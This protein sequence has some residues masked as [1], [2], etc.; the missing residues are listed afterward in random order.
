VAEASLV[1]G[2]DNIYAQL[3]RAKPADGTTVA[4]W[5]VVNP[6]PQ[7]CGAIKTESSMLDPS[8]VIM[9]SDHGIPELDLFLSGSRGRGILF[10]TKDSKAA[11]KV[12]IPDRG[13]AG[14]DLKNITFQ[15]VA[16]P[17]GAV[18]RATP[19]DEFMAMMKGARSL[20][21]Q[22]TYGAYDFDI[23][24]NE[25]AWAAVQRCSLPR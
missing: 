24:G 8:S 12:I 23:E 2:Y 3:H 10:D 14:S 7:R 5:K 15:I 25:L 1:L 16:D 21:I 22:E 20:V 4:G 11:L 9:I 6:R 18:L 17:N 13:V 19:S